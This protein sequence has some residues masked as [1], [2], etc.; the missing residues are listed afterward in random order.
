MHRSPIIG[1]TTY[2]RSEAGEF[3]LPG[4]YVD[5]IAAAGGTPLLLPPNQPHPARLLDAIDGLVFSGGGDIDPALYGGAPHPT[6]YLVDSERDEFELALAQAALAAQ[7]PVLGICRGMQVLNVASGGD[8]VVHVPEAYGDAIA[9][10][11]DHPRRP[12]EHAVRVDAES[13][14]AAW[15]GATECTIVSW[16][17]QAVK[18]IPDGWRVVAQA[19][20]GLPEAIEHRQHPVVALQWHPEMSRGDAV[21]QRLFRSFVQSVTALRGASPVEVG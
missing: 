12:T 7:L 15:L 3:Y 9:H 5:A 8:L 10:R 18:T 2:S 21:Q 1:I 4:A 6:V 17:H 20:D 16:H 19:A 14:L 11:L 13:R